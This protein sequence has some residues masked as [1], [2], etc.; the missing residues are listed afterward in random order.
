MVESETRLSEISIKLI[1]AEICVSVSDALC[2]NGSHGDSV[3]LFT[4]PSRNRVPQ[5]HYIHRLRPIT[6]PPP[7][8]MEMRKWGH[9]SKK[10]SVYFMYI[11]IGTTFISTISVQTS[12][13]C[14][15][16]VRPNELRDFF[17]TGPRHLLSWRLCRDRGLYLVA[18]ESIALTSEGLRKSLLSFGLF[19]LIPISGLRF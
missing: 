7:S 11:W 2:N 8:I 15:P 3:I 5:E 4:T 10:R 9:R 13:V 1:R 17:S 16:N 6:P 18:I 12:I 14:R 19:K